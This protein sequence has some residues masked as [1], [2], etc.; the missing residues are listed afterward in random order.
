MRVKKWGDYN[1]RKRYRKMTAKKTT[2][3]GNRGITDTIITAK[4][5]GDLFGVRDRMVRTLAEQG[6]AV[7]ESNGK[8][9]LFESTKNYIVLLKAQAAGKRVQ[10][11]ATGEVLDLE[12]ERALHE[13]TKRQITE[14]KLAL[15]K[16]QTHKAEDVAA[17][18]TD[19]FAKIKSKLEA[20]PTKMA[21]RL[22]NK[23][24]TQIQAILTEEVRN[25]LLE[26]SSYDPADFYSD[27]H[28]EIDGDKLAALGIVDDG[29]K[30]E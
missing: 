27:E 22:E 17:V 28:I 16:G 29:D 19:I 30:E 8:Y 24:R 7:R 4:Q 25:V 6:I 15:I 3:N 26:L 5:L 14:I 2:K 10:D 11:D 13:H 9:R 20:M 21:R 1:K 18:M 23:K 12:Q